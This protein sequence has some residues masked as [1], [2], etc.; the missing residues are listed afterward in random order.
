MKET[1]R[2]IISYLDEL[3]AHAHPLPAYTATI[4]GRCFAVSLAVWLGFLGAYLYDA[5]LMP[6]PWW[7]AALFMISCIAFLLADLLTRN[8]P[9]LSVLMQ[10]C[11]IV[12]IGA[13][14]IQG[15][16]IRLL[17]AHYIWIMPTITMLPALY[18]ALRRNLE[19]FAFAGYAIALAMPIFAGIPQNA[20]S[21]FFGYYFALCLP[22]P[23]AGLLRHWRYLNICVFG[24]VLVV[25]SYYLISDY[26]L[27]AYERAQIFFA[28][29]EL[30]FFLTLWA[31]MAK[32]PFSVMN[33]LDFLFAIGLPMGG[34]VCQ[35]RIAML[36]SDGVLLSLMGLV[37]VFAL[38]GMLGRMSWGEHGRSLSRI[39]FFI[40]AV[41]LNS[42]IAIL[43][44]GTVALGIYCAQAVLMF[45]FGSATD[46][47]RIKAGGMIVFM[48]TPFYF[49]ITEQHVLPGSMF[50]AFSALCCA[51]VQDRELKRLALR[52]GKRPWSSGLEFF[53]VLYGF[54]WCFGGLAVYA[55]R[56][57][58]YPGLI[59]FALCSAS[60]YFFFALGKLVRLR[61]LRVAI[62]IPMLVSI[63]AVILPF[64][65]QTRL[66]WPEL[67]HLAS[68]NYLGGLGALAWISYFIT[69]WTALFHNWEGLISKRAHSR[70][71]CLITLELVLVLTSSSRAFA[72]EFGVSPS[73]L[74]VLAVLPSLCCIFVISR[75]MKLRHIEAPYRTPMLLV[76]PWMLFAALGLWF[77]SSLSSP[78]AAAPGGRYVPLLNPVELVQLVSLVIFAYWQRRLRKSSIPTRHLSGGVRMWVYGLGSFLWLHGVMFR[79]VQYFSQAQ[80]QDVLGFVELRIIFA[81]IWITY[82][83][84]TW[85][86]S[87]VYISSF[88]WLIGAV[89]FALG[90]GTLSYLALGLWGRFVAV[91]VGLSALTVLT[92]LLWRSPAPFTQRGKKLAEQ[93]Y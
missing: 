12:A 21:L 43:F 72:L 61:S 17:S 38:V 74:S 7:F 24:W 52:S 33:L 40:A 14:L 93:I 62:F 58:P 45:W 30:C 73:L 56:D 42:S 86:G 16:Q 90:S 78:G 28:L 83:I 31:R 1:V 13:S 35:I 47:M 6:G 10:F 89:L 8:L 2:R 77:V 4:V 64:I 18:L 70:L 27:A 39:Y 22:L 67:S 88:S 19:I 68:Y 34:L 26:S 71:L 53:M 85:I 82:G 57:M 25:G 84:L 32:A 50:L 69:V 55:F 80:S 44:S 3:D 65:Y 75:V 66:E 20:P 63:P 29:F 36:Y 15:G 48:L 76:V 23:L 9:K 60:A 81:C 79:V 41:L 46:I 59:Y 51:Y 5:S 87:T 54:A 37:L 92:L 11:A 49:F 91:V